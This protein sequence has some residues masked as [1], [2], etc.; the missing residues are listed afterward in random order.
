MTTIQ[1]STGVLDVSLESL[2]RQLDADKLLIVDVF[3]GQSNA[4]GG[5]NA[6]LMLTGAGADAPV[7]SLY[8]IDKDGGV[9]EATVPH[10]RNP[11]NRSGA[12][13]W[14]YQYC[15]RLAAEG[16]NIA[17]L[18]AAQ[19]GSGWVA[20]AGG[21]WY[22]PAAYG[23][24]GSGGTGYI[25]VKNQLNALIGSGRKVWWR[26]VHIHQGE[27]DAGAGVSTADYKAGILSTINGWK[28][29]VV[30]DVMGNHDNISVTIGQLGQDL[31][32]SGFTPSS[33]SPVAASNYQ[34]IDAAHRELCAENR[35]W[36][37]VSSEGLDFVDQGAAGA[38]DDIHFDEDAV[39]ELGERYYAAAKLAD[40]D[41]DFGEPFGSPLRLRGSWEWAGTPNVFPSTARRGDTWTSEDQ[42][43]LG[44]EPGGQKFLKGDLLVAIVDNPSTSTY[45][46]NW[47]RV[48]VVDRS[49]YSNAISAPVTAT[50]LEGLDVLSTG[51]II[52]GQTFEGLAEQ[53]SYGVGFSSLL[54]LGIDNFSSPGTALKT[55][56]L[57]TWDITNVDVATIKCTVDPT[58]TVAK[59]ESLAQS[60]AGPFA[61]SVLDNVKATISWA[62]SPAS[63]SFGFFANSTAG[64]STVRGE[65]EVRLYV[66]DNS[67]AG[68]TTLKVL[69]D[70]VEIF[71]NASNGAEGTKLVTIDDDGLLFEVA[72]DGPIIKSPDG[73]KHRITVANDGTLG[74]ETVA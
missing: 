29:E 25:Q 4:A 55:A 41:W 44:Q 48:P 31:L 64:E 71:V 5:S 59:I 73:T 54:F 37:F 63:P 28:A 13:N 51:L 68:R 67:S 26:R 61:A 3:V 49:D 34:A 10:H 9:V 47:Q 46:G 42:T 70:S 24:T 8:L 18:G 11:G 30:D 65:D 38:T 14:G 36:V 43:D 23:G 40:I 1:G 62:A 53:A 72:G 58:S 16:N 27:S 45:A 74:T 32:T 35:R 22:G 39:M 69:R 33:G 20:A 21:I 52:P 19:G 60:N 12:R 66:D 7:Q 50:R 6:T 57:G 56:L 17:M 2:I 15:K